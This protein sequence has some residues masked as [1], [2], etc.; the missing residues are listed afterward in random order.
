VTFG[1]L[2]AQPTSW[3]NYSIVVPVPTGVS[4]GNIIVQ[5][6]VGGLPANTQ[7]FSVSTS[8]FISSLSANSSSVDQ[9]V[10]ITGV[11][12]GLSQGSSTVTFNGSA[13]V[14]DTWTN[15]SIST[16]VPTGAT[17]GNIVVNVN[18]TG[19][20]PVSFMVAAPSQESGVGF[21]QGNYAEI[22]PLNLGKGSLPVECYQDSITG[23][24]DSNFEVP[25]PTVQHAGDLN[26]V[27]VSWRDTNADQQVL[28]DYNN[29]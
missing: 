5:V 25:F 29:T 1:G 4:N 21:V 11:N 20:N 6:I 12:F 8:P 28:S 23:Y 27:I 22:M 2:A 24:L 10:T 7:T 18:G 15:T 13:A 14:V 3:N 9:E 19:S 26:V 17:T 16:L